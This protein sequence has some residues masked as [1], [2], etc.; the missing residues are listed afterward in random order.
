MD[1]ISNFQWNHSTDCILVAEGR[2]IYAHK[3]ILAFASPFFMDLF[4]ANL[5]FSRVFVIP[6]ITYDELRW[7]LKY[8]YTG[9]VNIPPSQVDRFI[10]ILTF[11]GIEYKQQQELQD[12]PMD[13]SYGHSR[14]QKEF[15]KKESPK[16]KRKTCG[17]HRSGC[18]AHRKLIF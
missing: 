6:G 10:S 9:D 15:P 3:L 14:S 7:V 4:K 1:F 17:S 18:K 13:G 2:P 12:D 16:L 11:F 8:I 5:A